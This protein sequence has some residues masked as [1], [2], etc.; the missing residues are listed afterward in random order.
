LRASDEQANSDFVSVVSAADDAHRSTASFSCVGGN[1]EIV[2]LRFK[3]KMMKIFFSETDF[4]L[5]EHN[6]DRHNL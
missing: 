4:L 2:G 5:L 6:P 3:V 1:L